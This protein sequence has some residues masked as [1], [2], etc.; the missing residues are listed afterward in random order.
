MGARIIR[1]RQTQIVRRYTLAI[2]RLSEPGGYAFDCDEAGALLDPSRADKVAALRASGE[3]REPRVER[4][5][6]RWTQPALAIC[7]VCDARITLDG[8]TDCDCGATYNGGGQ[9]L[10]PA[11]LWEEPWDGE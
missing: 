7:E 2:D 8:D 1:H 6:Y 3:F 4:R 10:V 9:R 11:H 5:T